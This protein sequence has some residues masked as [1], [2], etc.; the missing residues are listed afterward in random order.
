MASENKSSSKPKKSVFIK[1]DPDDEIF[2]T[3]LKL[4]E[5]IQMIDE[6]LGMGQR[7]PISVA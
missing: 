5:D 6:E 3:V 1:F 4:K 7:I 2:Q